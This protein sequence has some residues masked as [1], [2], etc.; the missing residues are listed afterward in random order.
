MTFMRCVRKYTSS[1]TN[2]S[3]HSSNLNSPSQ[4]DYGPLSDL[5]EE[6]RNCAPKRQSRFPV[7]LSRRSPLSPKP[8]RANE[9]THAS[10]DRLPRACPARR[11]TVYPE[12]AGSWD[13]GKRVRCA[14][15]RSGK[16]GR[17]RGH[18]RMQVRALRPAS[19]SEGYGIGYSFVGNCKRVE[20][21]YKGRRCHV[22]AAVVEQAS[23]HPS[24]YIATVLDTNQASVSFNSPELTPIYIYISSNPPSTCASPSS[25]SRPSCLAPL[26]PPQ[27]RS[28]S[29]KPPSKQQ[30]AWFSAAP[31]PSS[32]LRAMPGIPLR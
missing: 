5:P 1:N 6:R 25:A 4:H 15:R 21:V 16:D 30:T 8:R 23:E 18:G 13:C 11:V 12:I 14:E 17:A 22:R 32:S 20:V 9:R 19:R 31:S 27:N 3:S 26:L 29:A 24:Q 2:P 28:R 10:H 7:R